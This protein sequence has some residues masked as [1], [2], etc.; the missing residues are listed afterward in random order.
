MFIFLYSSVSIEVPEAVVKKQKMS[1]KA[2]PFTDSYL[3]GE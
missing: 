3:D 1:S 2:L